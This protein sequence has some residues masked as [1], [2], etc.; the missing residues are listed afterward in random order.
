MAG[1]AYTSIEMTQPTVASE[2]TSRLHRPADS[3]NLGLSQLRLI[4]A[5]TL[6][7][8]PPSVPAETATRTGRVPPVAV[9]AEQLGGVGLAVR[10]LE[11]ILAQLASATAS[12]TRHGAPTVCYFWATADR[13]VACASLRRQPAPSSGLFGCASTKFGKDN[14]QGPVH[15]NSMDNA[16]PGQQPADLE[17]SSRARLTSTAGQLLNACCVARLML[18]RTLLRR[19]PAPAR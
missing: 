7:P 1:L 19:L 10:L 2:V 17:V 6:G 5:T 3:A 4:A 15:R 13:G 16:F 12:S 18:A 14:H 8:K 9:T 11:R